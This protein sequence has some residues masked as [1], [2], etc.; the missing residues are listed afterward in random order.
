MDAAL[1]GL[2]DDAKG[3]VTDRAKASPAAG[4]RFTGF[5]AHYQ[6]YEPSLDHLSTMRTAVHYMLVQWSSVNDTVFLF[7]SWPTQWDVTFRLHAP[8]STVIEASC[9]GGKL[10]SLTVTPDTREKDIKVINCSM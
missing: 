1:L 9:I 7:P 4:W 10:K 2:T 3:K 6:D 5:A 8:L